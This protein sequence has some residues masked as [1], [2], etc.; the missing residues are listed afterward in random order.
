MKHSVDSS[1]A[2]AK[3]P[4]YCEETQARQV[5]LETFFSGKLNC[6][7]SWK[8][9]L[10]LQH[11]HLN[12]RCLFFLCDT[13]PCVDSKRLNKFCILTRRIKITNMQF[14]HFFTNL[15]ILFFFFL[16]DTL[17]CWQQNV[18]LIWFWTRRIK[19]IAYNKMH[20]VQ[21]TFLFVISLSLSVEEM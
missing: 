18:K 2:T 5:W 21:T 7:V 10:I 4:V 13:F 17:L 16:C 8:R 11:I 9:D 15:P 14:L 3:W 12:D 20:F 6:L 19:Y 1:T